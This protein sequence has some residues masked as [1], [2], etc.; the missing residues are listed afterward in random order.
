MTLASNFS[1]TAS[2]LAFCAALSVVSPAHADEADAKH[3]E[4][5]ALGKQANF[6]GARLKLLQALALRPM[7]KTFLNLCVVEQ[8]L[9]LEHEAIKHCRQFI[10]A[11]DADPSM[12]KTVQD[13]I[14]HELEAATGR[15]TIVSEPGQKV[16]IDGRVVGPTSLSL[17]IDLKAGEHSCTSHGRTVKVTIHGGENVTVKLVFGPGDGPPAE[18]KKGSWAVPGV[19]AGIGLAGIG[20]GIVLGIV[21]SGK[22][23]TLDEA[24]TTRSCAGAEDPACRDLS[25]ALSGGKG[26]KTG[27]FIAYGVGGAAVVGAIL[28]TA[29]LTPWKERPAPSDTGMKSA[30]LVPIL[31]PGRGE[32]MVMG[33]F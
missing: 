11:K 4:G 12:V 21:A 3:E 10:D 5:L 19:M 32:L 18:T 16:E 27:S 25:D 20:A 30:R 1:K 24:R 33:R 2:C 17:P 13:G 23:S 9:K 14:M 29:V 15:V 6:E 7:A 22:A 8:Q 28:A 26:M 31:E